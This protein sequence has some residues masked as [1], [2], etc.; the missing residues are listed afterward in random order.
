MRFTLLCASTALAASLMLSAC[1]GGAGSSSAIPGGTS[2]APMAQ[3][4]HG[5]HLVS[6]GNNRPQSCQSPY[7]ICYLAAP[8]TSEQFGWCI[9]TSGNCT[10]GVLTDKIKWTNDVGGDNACGIT[11]KTGVGFNA[12][13]GCTGKVKSVWGPPKAVVGVATETI[14]VKAS[15]QYTGGQAGYDSSWN[16]CDVHGTYKGDCFGPELAGVIVGPY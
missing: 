4:H 11:A 8:G 12:S 2:S 7:Y 13:G 6:V 3:K 1:S 15:V 9:S 14:E 16:A 10:S 5:Y